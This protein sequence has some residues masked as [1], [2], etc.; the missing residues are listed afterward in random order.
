MAQDL[1]HFCIDGKLGGIWK[2]LPNADL[3]YD[4]HSS[5]KFPQTETWFN[6][7]GKEKTYGTAIRLVT[8]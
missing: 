4:I 7:R 2:A 5:A 8:W 3:T 1:V 6:L